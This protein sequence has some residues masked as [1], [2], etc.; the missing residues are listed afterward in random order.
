M[1]RTLP[2]K[3]ELI[4]VSRTAESTLPSKILYVRS[5]AEEALESLTGRVEAWFRNS[6]GSACLSAGLLAALLAPNAPCIEVEVE[7]EAEV[8]VEVEVELELDIGGDVVGILGVIN[9]V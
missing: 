2:G 3:S 7:V 5:S 8:E 1:A 4:A 9:K 6:W